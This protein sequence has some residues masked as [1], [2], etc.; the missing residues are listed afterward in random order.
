MAVPRNVCP[1]PSMARSV[2]TVAAPET[3]T[4]GSLVEVRHVER[5]LGADRLAPLADE[6]GGRGGSGGG[7][8]PQVID[9]DLSGTGGD[10]GVAG[11]LDF[12][13]C[14]LRHARVGGHGRVGQ[15][16]VQRD[17]DRRAG[18]IQRTRR[19]GAELQ[20]G[21]IDRRLHGVDLVGGEVGR[22]HRGVDRA[23][24]L[25]G[26]PHVLPAHVGCQGPQGRVGSC[27]HHVIEI[28]LL[29]IEAVGAGKLQRSGGHRHAGGGQGDLAVR[30]DGG[31][32]LKPYTVADQLSRLRVEHAGEGGVAVDRQAVALAAFG[33]FDPTDIG[34]GA[35]AGDVAGVAVQA[36]LPAG[37]A[38]RSR[39]RR[40]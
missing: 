9:A 26:Q 29:R 27:L 32:G 14:Y 37:R 17:R 4:S 10:H 30:V 33:D 25:A 2:R 35:D 28:Q 34:V 12:G 6:G 31:F 18:L 20:G 8:G 24:G 21:A 19:Y 39:A 15:A 3:G 11:D 40:R 22:D 38:G 36:A 13:A 16:A 1:P 7:V 5:Y 23:G